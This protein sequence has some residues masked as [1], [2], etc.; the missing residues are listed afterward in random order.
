MIYKNPWPPVEPKDEER[1]DIEL[2]DG[3]TAL[4]VEF[5]G[6]GGGFGDTKAGG[7]LVKYPLSEVV[8]FALA[9]EQRSATGAK[10]MTSESQKEPSAPVG[11]S[12][13]FDSV[14]TSIRLSWHCGCYVGQAKWQNL[15]DYEPD[16]CDTDF[17][18]DDHDRETWEEKSC[19]ATCPKCGAELTQKSD[20]PELLPNIPREP[21]AQN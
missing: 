18:T 10:P 15:D 8:S 20:D 2:K 19:T 6:F 14:E 16:E 12:D 17:E 5:W 21:D 11:C 3:S 7:G 13:G 1:Y 9:N 4:N